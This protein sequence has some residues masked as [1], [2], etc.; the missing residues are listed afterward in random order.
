MSTRSYL[1]CALALLFLSMVPHSALGQQQPSTS[2]TALNMTYSK[3][4]SE[5][6]F[7]G[8]VHVVRPNLDIKAQRMVVTFAAGAGTGQTNMPGPG[9]EVEKIVA[10]GDVVILRDEYTGRS[11]KATYIADQEMVIME[12]DPV[13]IEGEN[14]LSGNVI[15]FYLRDNRSEVVGDSNQPVKLFFVSPAEE[16]NQ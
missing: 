3:E 1:F 9:G 14:S 2:I 8:Q 6:V 16:D 15:R 4:A 5:A 13:I 10:T 11:G 12:R 7:E